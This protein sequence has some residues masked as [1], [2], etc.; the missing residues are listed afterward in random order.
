MQSVFFYGLFMDV[1]LLRDMGL[2]PSVDGVAELPDFTLSIGD[3]ATLLAAPGS[4][5]WGIVMTLAESEVE[6]LYSVPGVD[7]YRPE[8]VTVVVMGDQSTRHCTCYNITA[9]E[10]GEGVN[11]EY[12]EQLAALAERMA[13]PDDYVRHIRRFCE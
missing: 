1:A 9:E 13:F 4:S 12:A 3:K 7:R 5:A 6:R 2:E 11:S 10:L 8:I